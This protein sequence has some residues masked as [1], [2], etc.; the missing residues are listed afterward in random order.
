M[1]LRGHKAYKKYFLGLKSRYTL[2]QTTKDQQDYIAELKRLY[3]KISIKAR[4]IKRG[5]GK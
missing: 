1:I 2:K 5:A 3:K 4:K